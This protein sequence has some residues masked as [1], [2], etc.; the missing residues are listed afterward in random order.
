MFI[1]GVLIWTLIVIAVTT[2]ITRSVMATKARE[3]LSKERSQLAQQQRK[4]A[5][6]IL[7]RSHVSITAAD[8]DFCRRISAGMEC[9]YCEDALNDHSAET[10]KCLV[11]ECFCQ[12]KGD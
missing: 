6:D 11:P 8:K 4:F 9:V 3:E 12:G 5:T 7:E 1:I 2:L 10:G